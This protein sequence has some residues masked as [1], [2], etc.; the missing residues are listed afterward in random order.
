MSD[1]SRK[2]VRFSGKNSGKRV[3]LVWRAS[4]S[5]SAKSVFTETDA[6]TIGPETL[7][8]RRDWR[9]TGSSTAAPAAGM[10]PPPMP[11]VAP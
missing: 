9:R 8:R 7:P 5:V 4:T 11:P 6:L 3:R 1:P 10:P 2:N